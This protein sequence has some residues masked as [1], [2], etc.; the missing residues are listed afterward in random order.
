MKFLEFC[1][2]CIT[3]KTSRA[4]LWNCYYSISYSLAARSVAGSQEVMI[5]IALLLASSRA[6]NDN[7]DVSRAVV[8]NYLFV[9][10]VK[11]GVLWSMKH[12]TDS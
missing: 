9:F 2:S 1:L 7:R 11:M 8:Y 4:A 6:R 12:K 10:Q 3:S 5:K